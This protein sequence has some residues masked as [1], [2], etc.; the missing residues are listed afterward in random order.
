MVSR[1]R[2]KSGGIYIFI[3]YLPENIHHIN[4]LWY[5]CQRSIDHLIVYSLTLIGINGV[6]GYHL[7]SLAHEV[8]HDVVRRTVGFLVPV[9]LFRAKAIISLT[10]L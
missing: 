4:G 9:I 3:H 10:G 5:L 6:D 8:F 2:I 7:V 1:Y